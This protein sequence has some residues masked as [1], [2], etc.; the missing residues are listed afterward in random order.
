MIQAARAE[1]ASPEAVAQAV[2]A[3]RRPPIHRPFFTV[4][5]VAIAA[6]S[7]AVV[8]VL[9]LFTPRTSGAWAQ[10]A[11]ETAKQNRYHERTL[12]RMNGKAAG[13]VERWID[14]PRFSYRSIGQPG[15]GTFGSDGRRYYQ[16]FTDGKYATIESLKQ[17]SSEPY[18]SGLG[19]VKSLSVDELIR[20]EKVRPVGEAKEIDTPQGKRLVYSVEYLADP[21]KGNMTVTSTGKF[22]TVP[23]DSRI[24]RWELLDKSG[25]W[26]YSGDVDYPE[27]IPDETFAFAPAPGTKVYD[28]DHG[29]AQ[30]RK[31][32]ERGYGTKTVNGQSVTL[33][34]VVAGTYGDLHVLWTGTPPNGDLQ[35]PVELDVPVRRTYGLTIMT[36]KVYE[37]IPPVEKLDYLP[38]FLGG[39]SVQVKGPV[40][41]KVTVTVPV[42]APDPKR[43]VYDFEGRKKGFRSRFV[44]RVTYRDVPV[45]KPGPFYNY[46]DAL[47][48]REPTRYEALVRDYGKKSKP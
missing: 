6:T 33:R 27:R 19:K 4:P 5:R 28:L 21:E 16:I 31:T 40:P 18:L 47:G 20:E 48:L 39:M 42:F 11:A 26:V 35:P 13:G 34:A 45:I 15:F 37:Y 8:M 23:G 2:R 41:D 38:T 32:M 12:F 29:R 3:L 44:G 43:P 1:T 25:E 36:T 17:V 30:L 10:V 22:Y 14:G 24:R 46:L 7:L 9:P